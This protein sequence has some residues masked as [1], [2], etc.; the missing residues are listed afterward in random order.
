MAAGSSPPA[1]APNRWSFNDG[2]P[3]RGR[4]DVVERLGERT[5]AHVTLADGNVVVAEAHRDSPL[6]AGEEVGLRYDASHIHLFDEAGQ[7][8]HGDS[9]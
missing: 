5:L 2:S 6:T 3:I 4:A 7:A 9:N 8:Y 1:F